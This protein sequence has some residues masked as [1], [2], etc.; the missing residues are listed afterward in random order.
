M[1]KRHPFLGIKLTRRHGD[2]KKGQ[3]EAFRRSVPGLRMTRASSKNIFKSRCI[4]ER[5]VLHQ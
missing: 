1:R 3:R 5:M 2:L 4:S